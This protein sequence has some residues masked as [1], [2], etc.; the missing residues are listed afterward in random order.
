MMTRGFRIS[1]KSSHIVSEE[2]PKTANKCELS[3]VGSTSFQAFKKLWI[4][5]QFSLIHEGRPANIERKDYT[6]LLYNFTLC[7]HYE[8]TM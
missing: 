1:G 6:Q 2:G 8:S 5:R 7:K 4:D 3:Q